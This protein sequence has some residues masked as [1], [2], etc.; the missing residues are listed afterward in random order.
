MYADNTSLQENRVE[1][2]ESIV[3]KVIFVYERSTESSHIM[4][5]ENAHTI[6]IHRNNDNIISPFAL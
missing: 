6:A 2:F 1:M 5:F 4:L 3:L